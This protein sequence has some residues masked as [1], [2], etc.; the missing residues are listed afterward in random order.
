MLLTT[1]IHHV[2]SVLLFYLVW[3]YFVPVASILPNSVPFGTLSLTWIHHH[4][5]QSSAK[6]YGPDRLCSLVVTVSSLFVYNRAVNYLGNPKI[7]SSCPISTLW[8]DL[9]PPGHFEMCFLLGCDI[10]KCSF[11]AVANT[12]PNWISH[13]SLSHLTSLATLL[14]C[15]TDI[16]GFLHIVN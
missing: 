6:L 11:L 15:L 10:V 5:Y 2:L 13:K 1:L 12:S 8:C 16:T 14:F 3:T 4:V 7:N 9:K